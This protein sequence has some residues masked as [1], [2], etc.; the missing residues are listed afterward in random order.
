MPRKVIVGI[1]LVIAVLACGLF[2]WVRTVF[3]GDLVRNALAA[4]L[5]SALGQPVTIGGIGAGLYPRITIT[6]K[7]V[8]IGDPVRIRARSLHVGANLGA[9]FSRRI[10]HARLELSDARVE[11]PLPTF[12]FTSTAT[13][14]GGSRRAPVELVSIDGVVLR[15]IDVISGGRMMTGDIDVV[16]EGRG[17]TLRKV[18]LR[19]DN[20]A[21][22]VTG[23][24]TDLAGPV[25]DLAITAGVLNVDRLLA[26]ANEFAAGSGM[27]T[28]AG[29]QSG[30][31]R[32]GGS[33]QRTAARP[34]NVSISLAA[35]RATIGTLVLDKLAGK[36]RL[37]NDAM[38][39]EPIG[40]GV[41]G[42]RYDGS[43]AFRLSDTPDVALRA[44]LTGVDVAAATRFVGNPGTISGTLSG[45]LNVGGRGLTA[46]SLLQSVRGG[47][48]VDIVDGV[49][50][51]LGL[52]RSIVVAT[53]GR[54]DGTSAA[55]TR[56]DEPFTRLG[57]TLT[58]GGGSASTSDLRFESPDLL[59]GA[60]GTLRLDGS[61]INLTGRAQLSDE[62]SRQAGRD[63]VRYTQEG[64]RVTLP[65]TVTGSAAAPHVRI[66]VADVAKRAVINRAAEEAQK[67]L[68]KG[69]GALFKR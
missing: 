12:S 31:R 42:G 10:E 52:V 13:P 43:L 48:R 16:P 14:P 26:F 46:A 41:F 56:R 18:R 17:V 34:M 58:I 27:T 54:A 49:V 69:L 50:N 7:E 61:S 35:D 55:A 66:D 45:K 2:L 68:K 30:S 5:S 53:S 3:T 37:T 28:A 23:R 67:A 59:L 57:A 25:G 62:L 6:L 9:L 22:D 20:A 29:T 51:N 32:N 38:R 11:L 63:L 4:Q 36:A 65:V 44:T 40:F 1:S 39:L 8:A 60:N 24:L 64:G 15:N 47:A 21:I 33:A 19:T